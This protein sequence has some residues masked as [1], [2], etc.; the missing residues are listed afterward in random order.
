MVRTKL[1]FSIYCGLLFGLFSLIFHFFVLFCFWACSK[2][3]EFENETVCEC[4][5]KVSLK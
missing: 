1:L 5:P 2:S 3:K 4:S